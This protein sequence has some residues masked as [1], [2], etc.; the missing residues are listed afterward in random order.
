M[1]KTSKAP[2]VRIGG[3]II[4]GF[5]TVVIVISFGMPDFMSRLNVNQNVA[6]LVNGEQ[7]TKLE[8]SRYMRRYK[9]NDA[10]P[11]KIDAKRADV[12]NAIIRKRLQV[13]Y[14]N[15]LGV[16]VTDENVA[17]TIRRIFSDESG[18]FN[19][20]AFKRTLE[21]QM[22][23]MTSFYSE[24]HDELVVSETT[25]LL[26]NCGVGVSPEEVVFQNAVN[27]AHF[28]IRFAFISTDD[29]KKRLGTS[30][31]VSD[32]EIDDEMMKNKK[33]IKDPATDRERFKNTILE[34]KID[35]AKKSI[36][37]S[38]DELSAK[39]GSFDAAAALL[40]GKVSLSDTFKPGE[41]IREPG[42]DGRTIYAISESDVF[43]NEFSALKPGMTSKAISNHDGVYIFTP[44]R[45][46]ITFDA[47]KDA[48]REKVA[49]QLKGEV[50]YYVESVV[51]RPFF[52]KAK[53]VRNI[54]EE[55][56]E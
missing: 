1:Y 35:A 34:H 42:K 6:A 5:L 22:M 40:G 43:R 36:V 54:K 26:S 15:K 52:E 18:K 23:S 50:A 30:L 20:Y 45:K 47:P 19:E 38:I 46:D 11:S 56:A 32:K 44:A 12:L 13:Q 21:A 39:D 8:L 7:I 14:S 31:I 2:I 3:Y 41:P 29:L 37:A 4:M 48:D 17:A 25:K 9:D 49:G 16:S 24:V 33:D 10:D 55:A 28:Q 53:I 27:N 51:F